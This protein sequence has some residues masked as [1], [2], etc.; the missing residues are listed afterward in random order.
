M[1]EKDLLIQRLLEEII[2]LKARVAELERR[3]RLNSKNSSKPPSSDGFKKPP[4][5]SLREKGKNPSGGQKGHEG[6]T[7]EQVAKPDKIVR[8][9]LSVCPHCQSVLSDDVVGITKRQV[10]D[11]PPVKLEVTE[12]QAE[13]KVCP[14]CGE[15]VRAEFPKGV[16]VPAQYGERIKAHSVYLSAQNFIPEDR[17]QTVFQDLYGVKI[18]TG[19]LVKFSNDFA[20]R[21]E[22]F[23]ESALEN[24]KLAAIKHADETGF[25]IGGKTIWLHVACDGKI[26]YYH[27]SSKRK[28]L[29]E[30]MIGTLVHDHWKPYFQMKVKHALCNAHHLR[31]L[32]GLIESKEVWAKKMKRILLFMHKYRQFYADKIPKEKLRR[33]EGMYTRIIDEGLV[34]HIKRREELPCGGRTNRKRYPGHNLLLRLKNYRS[35]VLRFLYDPNVPFTN[36]QAEQDVRMMKVKQRVSGGFRT[37]QGAEVFARLRTFLSTARKQGWDIF[38]VLSNSMNGEIPLLL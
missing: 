30:G 28:S 5:S 23:C 15:K 13:I 26:T 18:A 32:N 12:H 4:P 17:L 37:M 16:D 24:I 1:D 35:D 8:H 36:N 6:Q 33:L 3:L 2:W 22:G 31:E 19:T 27:V 25:R 7:L 9:E 11:I 20:K 10:F 14:C 21:L 34:Y 38:T 29:L